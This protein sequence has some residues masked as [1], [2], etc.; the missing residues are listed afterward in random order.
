MSDVVKCS[1]KLGL[2]SLLDESDTP[3]LPINIVN[4]CDDCGDV[5]HVIVAHVQETVS[6]TRDATA[7]TM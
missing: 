4:D 6:K 3:R 7:K 5:R 2:Q 1:Q